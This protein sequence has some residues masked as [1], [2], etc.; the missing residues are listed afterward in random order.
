MEVGQIIEHLDPL[1]NNK[2]DTSFKNLLQLLVQA[3]VT[4][5]TVM[6]TTSSQV[7]KFNFIHTVD[8]WTCQASLFHKMLFSY[9]FIQ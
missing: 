5:F 4:Q 7:N 2:N 8:V 1:Q 3:A 6:A 9:I